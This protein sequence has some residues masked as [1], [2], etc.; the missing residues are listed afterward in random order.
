MA[1]AKNTHLTSP[2]EGTSCAM[3]DFITT[4]QF[5]ICKQLELFESTATFSTDFW[6]RPEGGGG[7]SCVIE[8]GDVFEKGGVNISAVHSTLTTKKEQHLFQQL[9]AKRN[10]PQF[11]LN[12][13]QY[14]A[15]G[16]SLVLH[17]KNPFV[18]TVHMNY[19]YFEL[20]STNHSCW[21]FGGGTDLTPY[22]LYHDDATHFHV[23]LKQ[24]CDVSDQTY[25]PTFKKACD[26]YFYLPHRNEHRGIGGIFFDY[27]HTK[28]P[29]H[30]LTLVTNCGYSFTNAYLPIL[31]KHYQRPY[32]PQEEQWQR[33]RRGRYVEF[34]LLYDRGTL[35]GLKTNG[36]IDSIF[37]SL[38]PSVNWHYNQSI[39]KNSPEYDTQRH[40]QQ[41]PKDWI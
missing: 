24:A 23:T 17:P 32:T 35:F 7:K 15:T 8:H 37:M 36:R 34:N 4:L 27:L 28:S 40:V 33:Y 29:E 30:Y 38:P 3:I 21:W 2:F 14:V 26:D 18:P 16:I 10:L 12:N 1:N 31:K 5:D 13:A 25:Y 39:T 41:Q 20:R 6:T 22:Y 19:R 9:L 11:D